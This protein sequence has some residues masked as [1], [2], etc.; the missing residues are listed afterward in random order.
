V[1]AKNWEDELASF[2]FERFALGAME[3]ADIIGISSIDLAARSFDT[4]GCGAGVRDNRNFRNPRCGFCNASRGPGEISKLSR[5][6][7]RRARPVRRSGRVAIA[8]MRRPESGRRA[9]TVFRLAIPPAWRAL[10]D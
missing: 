9:L 7:R 1:V 6:L 4:I 2:Y 8:A 10:R 3:D 5:G